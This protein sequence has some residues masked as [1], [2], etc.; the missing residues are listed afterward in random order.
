MNWRM[1][2]LRRMATTAWAKADIARDAANE[3][4]VQSRLQIRTKD[5]ERETRLVAECDRWKR[6]EAR[7][8]RFGRTCHAE[9]CRIANADQCA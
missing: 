5:R 1:H 2:H 7:L 9:A 4:F 6:I 8:I 3:C